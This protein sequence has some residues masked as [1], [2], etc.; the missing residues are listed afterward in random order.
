MEKCSKFNIISQGWIQE[1]GTKVDVERT[2]SY[3]VTAP[4]LVFTDGDFIRIISKRRIECLSRRE[5]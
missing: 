1:G 4:V 3:T 5:A 2:V